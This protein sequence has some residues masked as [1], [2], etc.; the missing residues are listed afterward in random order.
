MRRILLVDDEINVLN[1][2]VRAMRQ[3]LEIEDL[4]IETF[5]DPFDALTR[6]AECTFDLVISDFRMPQ[7]TGVEFLHAIKEVAP[8][9]VRMILSA[10]TEF[11]TVTSAINDAQVFRFIPKPWQVGDLRENIR[12]AFEY[13][14][15][16]RKE[17]LLADRQR[18]QEG[19]LSKEELALRK[20][21]EEEPGLLKVKWGPNGEIIM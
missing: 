13:R 2:L 10:S 18:V 12:L 17:H 1:A 4:H 9:T 8:D 11:E 5:T 21:E 19:T 16:L 20:M 14:D 3:H 7:M 6:C 15:S